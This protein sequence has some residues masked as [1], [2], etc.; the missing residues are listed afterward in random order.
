MVAARRV[1][2]VDVMRIAVEAHRD[3]RTVQRVLAGKCSDLTRSAVIDAAKKLDIELP[4]SVEKG[5]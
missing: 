2:Q 4:A 3:Q 5:E 1:R